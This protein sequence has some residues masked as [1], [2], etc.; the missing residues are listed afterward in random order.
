MNNT[1]SL[2]LVCR[3]LLSSLFAFNS[4]ADE[5]IF[6]YEDG[7]HIWA[8]SDGRMYVVEFKDG[9]PN[10][11]GTYT[12][13]SGEKYAGEFKDGKFNGQGTWI[14]PDGTKYVGEWKDDMPWEGILYTSSG[15]VRSTVSS[16]KWCLR[17]TPTVRQLTI[18]REAQKAADAERAARQAKDKRPDRTGT[19]FIVDT[20]SVVTAWHVV[21]HCKK[22]TIYWHTYDLPAFIRGGDSN[23]DIALLKTN[24]LGPNLNLALLN[25]DF[26]TTTS[27]LRTDKL[28]LGEAVTN[29]GYPLFGH[30]ST[31]PTISRWGAINNL[32]GLNNNA[33]FF[34]YD[35]S[36][37]PGNSGGPVLDEYGNVVGMASHML[38]K[39]YADA[40]GH[41]AQNVNFAVKSSVI[42]DFLVDHYIYFQKNNSYIKRWCDIGC[43]YGSLP[44]AVYRKLELPDIA[45]KAERFTVLVKCWK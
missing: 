23:N 1:R 20:S 16:G 14:H 24:F 18:G 33:S 43:R 31:M 29:Y 37:Q 36:T 11:Q 5:E 8:H 19:G 2:F 35:A 39:K 45:D 40:T 10:G 41:I 12:F 13:P 21:D 26:G 28:R 6:G 34:Q 25:S 38:G 44:Q 3:F 32:N 7:F 9:L 22:V 4:Y 15:E 42:V 17:C 27:A 30:T